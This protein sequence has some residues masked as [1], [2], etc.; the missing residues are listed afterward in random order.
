MCSFAYC[1][2]LLNALETMSGRRIGVPLEETFTWNKLC[3]RNA[4]SVLLSAGAVP[5][6]GRVHLKLMCHCKNRLG[7][8]A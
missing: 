4:V 2:S 5:Q 3:G 6:Y 8:S 7:D 1:S